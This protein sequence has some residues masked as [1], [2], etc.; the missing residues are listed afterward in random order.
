MNVPGMDK[1]LELSKLLDMASFR[2]VCRSFSELYGI[3]I[4]VLDQRGKNIADV[5]SPSTRDYFGYLFSVHATKVLQTR[6]VNHIRTLELSDTGETVSV[7]CFSGLRYRIFPVLHEGTILGRIIFGPYAPSELKAPPQSLQKYEPELSIEVLATHLAKIP[8]ASEE[9]VNKVMRNVQKVLDVVIYTSYKNYLTSQMHIASMGAA[10]EDLEKTNQSLMAAND[11]LKELDRLKSNFIATVSHELRTPLT[12]IIGYAEMLT[13]GLA[14]DL[15][16]DQQ[17]YIQTVLEQS[18]SLLGLIG[19]VLD[20]SRIESGNVVLKKAPITAAELVEKSMTDVRPLAQ[21]RSLELEARIDEGLE[22][23]TVDGDKIRRVLTNLLGNAVKFSRE[24]TT[25]LVRVS[26]VDQKDGT[27]DVF[28]PQRNRALEVAVADQG[29]GI[30]PEALE[31]IFD[32]FYQVD[33]SS[34]R[35]FGGTGLGL[36]IVRNFLRAHDGTIDVESTEGE[37]STFTF[38]LPYHPSA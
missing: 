29:V 36:A 17:G 15:N 20:L 5:R 4:H 30:P 24:G 10:F 31:R 11:K 3:G 35:E 22:P 27:F 7:S 19:Q 25:I 2:E 14:G 6:L 13:E 28:E 9:V 32:S 16:P 21:K 1:R 34:T 38:T 26:L 12:S 18:E 8:R 37:G 23:I 33:N